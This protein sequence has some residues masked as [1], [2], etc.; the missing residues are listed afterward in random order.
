MKQILVVCPKNLISEANEFARCVGLGEN[1]GLTFTS[2]N[3]L[4]DSGNEYSV[5]SGLVGD[6]FLKEATS[7]LVEPPWGCNLEQAVLAQQALSFTPPANINSI[8]VVQ[9]ER[10]EEAISEIS[11]TRRIETGM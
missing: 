1:D 4:D 6:S 11:L 9:F 5:V 3:Y 10:L 7:T 2:L 8:L